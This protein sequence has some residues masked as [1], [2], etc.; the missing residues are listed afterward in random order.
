M[1]FIRVEYASNEW[2]IALIGPRSQSWEGIMRVESLKKV[3]VFKIGHL[4][5]HLLHWIY[6]QWSSHTQEALLGRFVVLGSE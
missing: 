1:L 4:P 2:V 5:Q 3:G 6:I